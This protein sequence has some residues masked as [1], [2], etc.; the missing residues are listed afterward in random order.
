[1][2]RRRT[3][4]LRGSDDAPYL[5]DVAL[6]VSS[7]SRTERPFAGHGVFLGTSGFTADG[8]QGTFYPA[9][10][11]SIDN[12]KFYSRQFQ[13]VEVD[14]TFYGTPSVA[15]VKSWYEK[16]PPDFIF[17]AKVPQVITH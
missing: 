7:E 3:H 15:T 13:T 14:S 16:T 1:M 17:A 2:K 12:L 8:W 5:F 4:F 9:G 6:E 11:K 10:M